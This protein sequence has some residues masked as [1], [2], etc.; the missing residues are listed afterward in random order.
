MQNMNTAPILQIEDIHKDYGTYQALKGVSLSVRQGEFIALVGPS[1]CGKTTLLKQI[2]G[3]EDAT[4]GSISIDGR[5]MAGVPAAQRPT[6][7][8]FQKLALFPHM[9]VAENI[10]FPLK[11]RKVVPA[12]IAARVND[13]IALMELK[14]IYL[15][16][17][18]RALV[19]W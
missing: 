9:T 16:R 15:D 11:L 18:P 2:A 8:V 12:E 14:P 6:S 10:G 3:F 1:G 13:M 4:S 5:D 17:L 19:G 7:M